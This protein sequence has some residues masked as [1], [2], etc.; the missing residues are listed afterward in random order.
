MYTLVFVY[1]LGS[2]IMVIVLLN[3]LIALM[4]DTFDQQSEVSKLLIIKDHLNFVINNWYLV[5][6]A[7][8]KRDQTNYL[9]AAFNSANTNDRDEAMFEKYNENV[10]EMF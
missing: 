3:M 8:P 6:L 5:S 7:L 1:F 9:I 2:F 4:G 10:Q